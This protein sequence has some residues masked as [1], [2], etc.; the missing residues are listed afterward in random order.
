[1][2]VSFNKEVIAEAIQEVLAEATISQAEKS[3]LK[4]Y[5]VTATNMQQVK[6]EL[7]QK[8]VKDVNNIKPG[9]SVTAEDHH[10][11]P[12]DDSDM[13]KSQL[14][15]IAK[16]ALELLQMIK[17]GDPLDAWVQAK[18]TKAADYVD[19]VQ[20]YLEGEEFLDANQEAPEEEMTEAQVAELF[21]RVKDKTINY[22]GHEYKI[23]DVDSAGTF[24]LIDPQ[25]PSAEP[26]YINRAMMKQGEVKPMPEPEVEDMEL[27]IH[28][29]LDE[30]RK[31][32]QGTVQ[33]D[34]DKV[35]AKMKELAKQYSAGD[36]SVLA[37]LKDLN[38]E[39][40][41]LEKELIDVVSKIGAGQEY[42]GEVDE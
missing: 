35:K 12:N 27:D 6:D 42:K 19:A 28:P 1:M 14:Y 20:H 40:K 13:A 23:I 10:E 3:K 15:A 11:N 33:S 34:L 7:R 25:D 29:D 8:G 36:K 9:S 30:A 26:F 22:K 31:R 37:Q 2:A 39:K 17:D 18:I 41:A 38:D 32:G 4:T 21:K 5:S 24:T 16:Y